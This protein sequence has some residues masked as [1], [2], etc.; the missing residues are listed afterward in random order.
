MAADV[1]LPAGQVWERE[2][3]KLKDGDYVVVFGHLATPGEVTAMGDQGRL[4]VVD[5][6]IINR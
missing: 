1:F 4:Y 5:K 3:S 2:K 6:L